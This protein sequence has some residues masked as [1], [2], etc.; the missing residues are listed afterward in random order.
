MGQVISFAEENGTSQLRRHYYCCADLSPTW[1]LDVFKRDLRASCEA[2]MWGVHAVWQAIFPLL[3]GQK[4]NLST[5][6]IHYWL[7]LTSVS[8]V[9][10]FY[11]LKAAA[12]TLIFC[13]TQ[14][15]VHIKS[16]VENSALASWNRKLFFVHKVEI[17]TLFFKCINLNVNAMNMLIVRLNRKL[18]FTVILL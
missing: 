17:A 1:T 14:K 5:W 9:Q 11:A 12:Y 13:I 15:C 6:M 4:Y 2:I 8:V 16:Y 3:W 10:V 7:V 18:S